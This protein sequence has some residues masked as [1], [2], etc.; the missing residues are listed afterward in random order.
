M[1]ELQKNNVF[2]M[3]LLSILIFCMAMDKGEPLALVFLA[4]PA[5]IAY[6]NWKNI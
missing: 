1:T 5:L 3:F 2:A 6:I 4:F